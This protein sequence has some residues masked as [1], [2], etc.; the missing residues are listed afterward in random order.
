MAPLP[1]AGVRVL[2]LATLIAAPT[3]ARYLADFGADVI[4]VERPGAGDPIRAFEF[5]TDGVSLWW[6]NISRNKRP[7]TLDLKH[8]DGRDVL[9]RLVESADVLIENFRPGTVERLGLGPDVLHAR[10]PGLVILR[11]TGYG[12][13]GPYSSRPG[14]G[15]L[16]EAYSGYAMLCGEAGHPP[17]LPPI[18]LADEVTALFGA[19]GVLTALYHRDVHGGSGQVID[20][21]LYESLFGLLGPLVSLWDRNREMQERDG[22][23]IG[24]TAPRNTY[25]A[26]DGHYVAL[27]GSSQSIAER[28]FRAIGQPEL[29]EDPRFSDNIARIENVHELDDIIG[30]WM[31]RHSVD[32]I[33]TR[34]EECE[35]AVAPVHDMESIFTDSHYQARGT[36]ARVEDDDLGEVRMQ[37]VFPRLS[38]TP[39][40]IRHTGRAM[41]ECTDEVLAEAG[42]DPAQIERL[43]ADGAV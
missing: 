43:H 3:C 30:A 20:A 29:F 38:D 36:I 31:R 35:A 11:V 19:L 16:A 8:P 5:Q 4:K 13:S 34:F 15:T 41:G 39:G 6:K 26:G 10:N 27:A 37:A 25:A 24:F 17:L 33:V 9:L 21:A 22:S 14:F 12:Q 32:E 23:R 7:I 40:G 1:L 2:D 28:I 18:A 42:Y